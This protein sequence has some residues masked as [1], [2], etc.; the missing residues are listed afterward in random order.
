MA[1]KIQIFFLNLKICFVSA[2]FTLSGSD[3]FQLEVCG[4]KEGEFP[5]L[6]SFR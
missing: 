5:P 4:G 1:I 3:V 6:S 2:R